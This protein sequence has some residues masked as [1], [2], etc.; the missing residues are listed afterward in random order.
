VDEGIAYFEALFQRHGKGE[1]S[2]LSSQTRYRYA[3]APVE[4]INLET[5]EHKKTGNII[6]VNVQKYESQKTL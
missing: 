6:R 4:E 2:D 3:F 5:L 1:Y